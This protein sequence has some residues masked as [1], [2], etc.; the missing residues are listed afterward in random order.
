MCMKYYF[1]LFI[2]Q[3]QNGL[4]NELNRLYSMFK[5]RNPYF[6]SNGGKVSVIAHSLG[7]VIVYDIVTGWIPPNDMSSGHQ[8]KYYVLYLMCEMLQIQIT[9]S[10]FC[11]LD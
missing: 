9:C 6:E 10:L 2:P 7:C 4:C 5:E 11:L 3:I 8:V 1:L